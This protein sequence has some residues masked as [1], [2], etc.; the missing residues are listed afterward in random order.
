MQTNFK[1]KKS[2]TFFQPVSVG[3]RSHISTDY[4]GGITSTLIA[5]TSDFTIKTTN[6]FNRQLNNFLS[7][8]NELRLADAS[9]LDLHIPNKNARD[10]GVKRAWNY[11]RADIVMGG[12]GSANWSREEQQQILDR[13]TVRGAEGHHQQNVANHPEHQA[14]PDNIKF[15]KSR[16]DHLREGHRGDFHNESNAPMKDKNQMLK[17]TNFKRVFK[18]ELRGV[19]IAVGI[20]LGIGF[21]IG[22][23][24]SLAQAGIAP[25]SLKIALME[26]SKG[27]VESG[28]MTGVGYGIGRTI[29]GIATLAIAGLFEN[30]GLTITD[31]IMRMF[32]MGVVGTLT[33]TVFSVYQFIKLKL[34]NI[35]TSDAFLNVGKQVLFSLSLLAV[36]I[37]A[38]GMWG[39]AAGIIVSVSSGIIMITYSLIDIVHQKEFSER[40]RVYIIEK[41]RPVY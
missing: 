6:N 4:S 40:V 27:A 5:D 11:E 28:I 24:V 38:Q 26:G 31:N 12:D 9:R 23:C 37:A 16:E 13:G 3:L 14:N 41:Y 18:N 8:F 35:T 20:G 30:I 19:G 17:N 21:T 33:I 22:F 34:N 15:Y 1:N 36:S 7:R 25:D 2:L 32:N 10:T 29:G 39:G